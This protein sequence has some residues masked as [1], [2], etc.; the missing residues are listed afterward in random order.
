MMH[1]VAKANRDI[2]TAGKKDPI[3]GRVPPKKK[4]PTK[5]R[6]LRGGTLV[7]SRHT[8]NGIHEKERRGQEKREEKDPE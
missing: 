5:E 4:K 1:M 3:S 8:N 6:E 2:G 7:E